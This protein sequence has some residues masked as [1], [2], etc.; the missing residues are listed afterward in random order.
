EGT[1]LI[2]TVVRP[3]PAA[4]L[5]TSAA[6]SVH[7]LHADY[8]ANPDLTGDPAMQRM[9]ASIDFNWGFNG[10][11]PSLKQNYSVR[12]TGVLVPVES[13]DY[14]LGFTGQDGYRVWV[15]GQLLV[16]DWTTHRPSTTLTKAIHLEQGHTYALKVEYFQTVRGAEAKL[17]WG[18][19]GRE[20]QE[21]QNAA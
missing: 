12:W 7:G 19:P 1:G 6:A 18:T 10:V 5:Y 14:V 13:A 11:S 15:D 17:V 21:A 4:Y 3:V 20:E 2:G 8:F 16:E 9:D